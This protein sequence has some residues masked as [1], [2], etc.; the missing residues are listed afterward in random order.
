MFSAKCTSLVLLIAVVIAFLTASFYFSDGKLISGAPPY[1]EAEDEVPNLNPYSWIKNWK[2]PNVPAKVGFQ[3]G[4]WDS[5]NL[6]Q[7]LEKL[8]NNTGASG[9][10]KWEWEVNKIIAEH[11]AEI[12]RNEGVYI[13]IIP[14]TVPPAYWADAFVA[15]HAD[16]SE[17]RQASGYKFAPPWRDFTGDAT[18]LT[19]MLQDE[20]EKAT[21][22]KRD[23]NITRNMR[24][25][26]AF[27][28][29]RYKHAVH[30][31]TTSVIVET[32]FIT[33]LSDQKFLINTPEIPSRAIAGGILSYLRSEGLLD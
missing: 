20:Y 2:R 12:L 8:R 19:F 27:S 24:G 5:K 10:G 9:G 28:W 17:N 30:P 1:G 16:G 15:I 7:E 14:A 3:V 26:Y 21:G 13:D 32:G 6:P 11:I 33:N 31:M 23:L 29:W 22:L 4:H 25:Y 18:T